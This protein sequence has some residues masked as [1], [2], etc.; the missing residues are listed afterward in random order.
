MGR[1]IDFPLT[2]RPAP[3][4]K[5]ELDKEQAVK[6]GPEQLGRYELWD[7][8]FL[9]FKILV[10]LTAGNQDIATTLLPGFLSGISWMG[11]RN[12]DF[13]LKFR[14]F[15]SQLTQNPLKESIHF[16]CDD[17]T[18][19]PALA[20]SSVRIKSWCHGSP[21]LLFLRFQTSP[22]TSKPET[23][24]FTNCEEQN[25]YTAKRQD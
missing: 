13:Y 14:F 7:V 24:I 12:I 22:F 8:M 1:E 11:R 6:V 3:A 5:P 9:F 15:E 10:K 20:Q 21:S 17:E 23:L 25:F 18:F 16:R 2:D 4:M 19:I